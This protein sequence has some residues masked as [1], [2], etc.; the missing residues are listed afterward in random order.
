MVSAPLTTQYS[1]P[2]LRNLCGS[3]VKESPYPGPSEGSGVAVGDLHLS[4]PSSPPTNGKQPMMLRGV[5]VGV[6]V[7]VGGTGVFV[8]VADGVWHAPP[9]IPPDSLS[10]HVTDRGVAVGDSTGV[11]VRA[12]SGVLLGSGFGV[13][14][15]VASGRGV[16]DAAGTTG[17]APPAWGT[18]AAGGSTVD[19]GG[20]AGVRCG[21]AACSSS[22]AASTTPGF[23]GGRACAP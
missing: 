1:N 22:R 2:K 5:A 10:P 20:A 17:V 8:G 16:L 3:A 23:S 13:G 14:V 11:L 21:S 15:S 18:A 12:G 19:A 6:I 4:P 7:G 9:E